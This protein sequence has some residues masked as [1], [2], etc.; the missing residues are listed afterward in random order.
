MTL[1]PLLGV[2]GKAGVGKDTAATLLRSRLGYEA[3]AFADPLKA[4][5]NELFGWSYEQWLD[6]EW[7]EAIQ[8]DIG[9][10]PRRAAQ[11]LGTEFAR[12][13]IRPDIWLILADRKIKRLKVLSSFDEFGTPPIVVTD[14][15]FDNEAQWV[16]DRGG[17]VLMIHRQAS[18]TVAA[19]SSEAGIDPRLIT[20]HISNDG[21]LAELSDKLVAIA[22][23][24][25]F[26]PAK[27]A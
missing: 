1:V 15:R 11:L 14:V 23:G 6:R 4:A 8:G 17:R 7:K 22:T 20:D 24:A 9:I 16:R 3:L 18:P 21:T 2:H 5:L 12:R 13:M 26:Q 25:A 27:E 19:H 10:S